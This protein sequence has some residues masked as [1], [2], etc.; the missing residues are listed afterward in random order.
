[1]FLDEFRETKLVSI[2]TE[3]EFLNIFLD[4]HLKL[5][6][7]N[8]KQLH[9]VLLNFVFNALELFKFITKRKIEP[10]K[11]CSPPGDILLKSKHKSFKPFLAFSQAK[12]NSYK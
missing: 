3:E 4:L 7:L 2:L 9:D 8:K 1:M 12:A 10:L 5:P 6:S 11:L